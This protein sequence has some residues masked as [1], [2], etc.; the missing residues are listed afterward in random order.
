MIDV[1]IAHQEYNVRNLFSNTLRHGEEFNIVDEVRK[2]SKIFQALRNNDCDVVLLGVRFESISGLDILANIS[3]NFS[4]PVIM[5]LEGDSEKE[6][7]EAV[8]SF[9]Y[10]A[11]DFISTEESGKNI[12][13]L[14][15]TV[16]TDRISQKVEEFSVE[17]PEVDSRPPG[18]ILFIGS[19]TGG[20]PGLESILKSLPSTFPAPIF[21]VQHMAPSMTERLAE[22]LN[23][24]SNVEVV[25][26]RK[27]MKLEDGKAFLAPNDS[28]LLVSGEDEGVYFRSEDVDGS[29]SSINKS[30]RSVAELYGEACTAVL[31]SGMGRDGALGARFLKAAG[32]TVLVESEE[33]SLIFGIGKQVV[34]QGDADLEL[35]VDKIAGKIMEVM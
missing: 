21:I 7:S 2:P 3:E 9:S 13:G 31:L 6:M 20:P 4:V 23:K 12:R 25:V 33:T 11:V 8:K 29:Y 34:R 15:K 5:I 26:G 19:S 17:E 30:L 14:V 10:G 24:V 18:K 16:A 1:V 35:P 28:N 32:G 22:R 27:G